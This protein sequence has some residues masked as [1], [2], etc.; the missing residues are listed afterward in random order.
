MTD[1][2][3]NIADHREHAAS[4]L[5]PIEFDQHGWAS[6]DSVVRFRKA[7]PD[8]ST[9][10]ASGLL[11]ETLKQQGLA[12][13]LDHIEG[14]V[15][16][17]TDTR[18]CGAAALAM[19]LLDPNNTRAASWHACVDRLGVIAQSVSAK[20]GSWHAGG[21]DAALFTRDALSGEWSVL[22][23]AQR[24]KIRGWSANSWTFGIELENAGQLK[25]VDGKWCSWPFAFGT[26]YGPPIVV[27]EGEVTVVSTGHGWHSFTPPQVDSAQRLLAALV[28]RY[29]LRRAA[30][31][32]THAVIDPKNRVDPGPVWAGF[33]AGV[34]GHLQDILDAV[35]GAG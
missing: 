24:G 19:R 31:S 29:G 22:T 20:C 9:K 34:R 10:K 17:Y 16:H 7:D 30:C 33:P 14:V 11:D 13:G 1:T 27:P 5:P 32:W 23:P 21:A 12:T 26:K 8:G 4:G 3:K 15:W 35:F 18:S 2:D 6:G 25:L 28:G